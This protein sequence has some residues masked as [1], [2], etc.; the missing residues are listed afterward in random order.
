MCDLSISLNNINM[1]YNVTELYLKEVS[2][3]ATKIIYQ[4]H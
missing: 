2:M 1:Q 3:R 4:K